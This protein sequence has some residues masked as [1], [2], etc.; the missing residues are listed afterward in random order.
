M[1]TDLAG[2]IAT[3]AAS[4]AAASVDGQSVSARPVGDLI[5]ADQYLAA[6]E[7]AQKR[8]RGVRF[9]K[10]VPPGP[11]PDDGRALMGDGFTGGFTG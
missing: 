10:L 4:P 11:L 1:A 8:R 6:K 2:T 7:A 3:A 9:S 5:T